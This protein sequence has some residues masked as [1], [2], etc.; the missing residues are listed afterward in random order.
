MHTLV[1]YIQY[2]CMNVCIGIN[3]IYSLSM[4]VRKYVFFRCFN[5]HTYIHTY[6]T[7]LTFIHAYTYTYIH[8]HT[9]ITTLIHIHIHTYIHAYIH[10]H[11]YI[12]TL[13]AYAAYGNYMIG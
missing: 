2:V 13:R 5:I 10:I 12:H 3:I 9:Y 1:V 8:T 7:T 11:T 6:I 4:N